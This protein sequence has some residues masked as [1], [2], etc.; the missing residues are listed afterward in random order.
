MAALQMKGIG[1]AADYLQELGKGWGPYEALEVVE[2]VTAP[3]VG[4]AVV[5]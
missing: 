5:R 1:F 3:L 4:T 2:G